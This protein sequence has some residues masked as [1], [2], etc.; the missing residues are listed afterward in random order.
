MY[1]MSKGKRKQ[2]NRDLRGTHHTKT[3]NTVVALFFL[4]KGQ[5]P[6]L[7]LQT[8]SALQNGVRRRGM[9][10]GLCVRAGWNT[11]KAQCN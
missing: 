2:V 11:R 1:M 3:T 10:D 7:L 5:A 9:Q 8:A 4:Q 6:L